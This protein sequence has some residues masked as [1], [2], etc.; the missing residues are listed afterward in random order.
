[1]KRKILVTLCTLACVAS[2]AACGKEEVL[3]TTTAVEETTEETTI[4]IDVEPET[5]TEEIVVEA[6][7]EELALEKITK[8][9]T[10]YF[11]L[12]N[13][14]D[15]VAVSMQYFTEVFSVPKDIGDYLDSLKMKNGDPCSQQTDFP[16]IGEYYFNYVNNDKEKYDF[17][18]KFE[19]L[20]SRDELYLSYYG[21]ADTKYIDYEIFKK[22]DEAGTMDFNYVTMLAAASYMPYMVSFNE[23]TLG[24]MVETTEYNVCGIKSAYTFPILFDGKDIGAFAIFS[25]KDELLNIAYPDEFEPGVYT[26]ENCSIYDIIP[27]LVLEEETTNV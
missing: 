22:N 17:E 26:W 2:L 5:E 18:E 6:S 8:L 11:D 15:P 25:G 1:M 3:E 13:S 24:E 27:D 20:E 12:I 23:I 16:M 9:K 10:A 19:S 21:T 7:K 4:V 14:K